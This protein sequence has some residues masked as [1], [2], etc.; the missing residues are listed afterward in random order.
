MSGVK[1]FTVGGRH[2]LAFSLDKGKV[3]GWGFN[4]YNQLGNSQ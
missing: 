3:F 2:G 1:S 4:M